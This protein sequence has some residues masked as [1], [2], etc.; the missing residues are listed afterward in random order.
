M[1]KPA[2]KKPTDGFD[3]VGDLS[4][5]DLA[6]ASGVSDLLADLE[7]T[8][9]APVEDQMT[10]KD[11][12]GITPEMLVIFDSLMTTGKY[13]ETVALGK[14]GGKVTWRTRTSVESDAIM[15]MVDNQGFSTPVAASSAYRKASIL[16]ALV[17]YRGTD[18]PPVDREGLPKRRAFLDKLPQE[19][20]TFLEQSL[21]QFDNKVAEAVRMVGPENF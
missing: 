18:L 12:D 8:A 19:F 10:K 2:S 21:A 11:D 6:I 1:T 4:A 20:V 3:A 16:V 7:S 15:R 17:N 9:P 14:R 13:E 5:D